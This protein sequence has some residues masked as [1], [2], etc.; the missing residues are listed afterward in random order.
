MIPKSTAYCT[1]HGSRVVATGNKADMSRMVKQK[2][3]RKKGWRLVLSPGAQV[4][5]VL[6][7]L[8]N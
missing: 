6:D 2:G 7:F 1:V 8:K 3:G 5:D 4:G